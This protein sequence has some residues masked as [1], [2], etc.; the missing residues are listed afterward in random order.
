MARLHTRMYVHFL[1]VLVVVGAT[2]AV[3][4]AL[5]ARDAFRREMVFRREM[6]LRL[7]RYVAVLVGEHITDPSGLAA[8]L[9]RIHE[10]LH[11]DL[12]VY[13]LDGRVIAS[14]GHEVPAL[15]PKEEAD[16]RAGSVVLRAHPMGLAAAPVRD[17][18]SGAVL[19]FVA[20]ASRG[21]F[22]GAPP[23]WR[24]VSVIVL[25]LL[26]VAIAT[27]PLSQ[28]ISRPV[29][30]LREAARRLGGGDLSARVSTDGS[31]RRR[32]DEI[33]ELTGAFNDMADRIERLVGAEK[34]LLANVSH[35]LRSPLAR[36]RVAVELLPRGV[37]ADRLLRDVE[38]DLGDLDRLIENVLTTARLDTTG[39][40][41]RLGIVDARVLLVDLAE[42]A[43]HDP[44]TANSPVTV[45]D[46]PSIEMTADEGLLRRAVW[47]LIEN[48][49]KYGAPPIALAA[50][51]DGESATLTVT[52]HGDGIPP[53]DREAVFAPFYRRDVA[54]TPGGSGEQRRG[55]GLGLTLAR[56][57]ATVHGGTVRVEA[58]SESE[59]PKGC[60]VVMPIPVT[61]AAA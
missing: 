50:R 59:R 39:L 10:D 6:A 52:D 34:E 37:D 43:R 30:R 32:A 21:A 14:A 20:G 51:R 49:A 47:N 38:R 7:S 29:E 46:G 42:R 8:R 11:V 12:R 28:R 3:V 57:I 41:A 53:E 19:G 15:T 35:E 23:I 55:F 58:V 16:V 36:I 31:H 9:E 18:S 22:G 17:P 40:P 61:S 45:D 25:V 48:A 44:L 33:T 4:F 13:D 24:P 2:A 27:R 5:G 1:V 54:R 60:R 56:R 26:V